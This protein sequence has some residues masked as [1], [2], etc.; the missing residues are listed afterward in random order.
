MKKTLT[1]LTVILLMS[2]ISL[3]QRDT[4]PL[5]DNWQFTVD[6]KGEGINNKWYEM[7]LAA[8]RTVQLPHTWNIEDENQR[9]NWRRVQ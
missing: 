4:I 7:P 3:A 9:A 6:K 5:N 1:F 8:A 2:E